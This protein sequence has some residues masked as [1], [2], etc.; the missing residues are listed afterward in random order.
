VIDYGRRGKGYVFGAFQPVT[1]EALTAPYGGR[2]IANWADFLLQVEAWLQPEEARVHAVLDNLSTHRA[3]N[4]A[5]FPLTF[6][7]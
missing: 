5:P 4:V 7:R 2:T 3:R 6:R 1:G